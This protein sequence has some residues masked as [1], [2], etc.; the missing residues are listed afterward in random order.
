MANRK[1]FMRASFTKV[2][3][4][5]ANNTLQTDKKGILL[6]VS[7]QGMSVDVK[8]ETLHVIEI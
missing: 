5:E 6:S 1:P 8:T 2:T 7:K 3:H 4:N